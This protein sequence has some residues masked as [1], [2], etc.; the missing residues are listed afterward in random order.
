MDAG[1]ADASIPNEPDARCIEACNNRKETDETC[2]GDDYDTCIEFCGEIASWQSTT[3]EALYFCVTDDP[4]CFQTITQCVLA[5]AY[6]DPVPVIA[7]FVGTGFDQ[8]EGKNVYAK[9]DPGR[10]DI[11]A[12]T[13]VTNGQHELVWE[14]DMSLRDLSKTIYYY[15]DVDGD[16]RCNP[17]T[18]RTQ[19]GNIKYNGDIKTHSFYGTREL[20]ESPNSA[21]MIC[22]GFN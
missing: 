17:Q 2:F 6:P 15:V 19:Y 14:V 16:A 21:A 10:L 13:L 8:F 22:R 1:S 4:L 11:P 12:E 20:Q 18:D 5:V 7:K 3:Q 9:L